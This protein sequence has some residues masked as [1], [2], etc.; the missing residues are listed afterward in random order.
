MSNVF[1]SSV[2]SFGRGTGNGAS[3]SKIEPDI[4]EGVIVAIADA[5]KS[6]KVWQGQAKMVQQI[7]LAIQI[8][9]VNGWGETSLVTDWQ[10]V[11][12]HENSNFS[13]NFL[14]PC[15]LAT[16]GSIGELVGKQIRVEIEENTEG[17]PRIARY[18]ATKKPIEAVATH[19]PKWLVEKGY[20]LRSHATVIPG[21][22]PMQP[23]AD[24]VAQPMS[25]PTSVPGFG[26]APVNPM[27]DID[28]SLPF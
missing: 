6:E 20:P 17:Y 1:D 9:H 23:K 8:E 10:T 15:K 7:V 5:G 4:Y 24:A 2:N 25:N 12:G 19:L 22:R 27:A 18:F 13:K 14:V 16:I 21:V 28:S 11:S 26:G 3:K